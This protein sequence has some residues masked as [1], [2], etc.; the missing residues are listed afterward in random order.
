MEE[1]LLATGTGKKG[2]DESPVLSEVKKQLRLAG[3]LVVG[4]LLQNVVQ[5][6][7]VMFVG[8]LGELALSAASMAT[9]F[10]N[11]TG[12]SLLAGMACSLDTLCGQAYGAGQHRMLGVYKQRAML[13]LSLASVPVAALWAYTGRIL[14]LLGQDPEI[15]A[16]AGGYIRWMIPALLAYGPLQCHVRFLQ[17]QNVVVPVMLS[18]GATALNHPLVCWAL[19]HGLRM[20][21]KGAALA[22]AVSFLTNLSI[23]ALYVRLSPSCSRTWTGFSR[24]AFRGLAGFLKLAVPSALMHGVVV[25]R[26]AGAALRPAPKPQAGDGGPVHLPEH[27]LPGV[28]GAARARRCHKHA[29]VERARGGAAGGGAAGGARG[30]A[31]G[32]GGGRVGGAGDAAGARRVGVRLQQRGGGGRLRRPDDAHP[33]HV[34]RV[35]RPPVR[36]LRRCQGLRAAEDGRIRQPRGV[37]PRRHSRGLLLR[38]RLPPW[39]NGAVVRDMVRAGGADALAPRHFR[40]RDRLGQRGGE[41]KGQSLHFFAASRYDD[42][43]S[44][45]H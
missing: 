21:S 25:V 42:V 7:S 9:S 10:A 12:F 33:R 28:H 17:T 23:L 18:S 2:D 41:G 45:K 1:Q 14:L 43:R 38:L 24:D 6:I 32:A 30:D 3:P 29:R 11:V 39:R 44:S 26:A 4:C 36:P 13:V 31:A 27:Q 22:N 34:R 5:M 16:G 35:R 20:G 15:A 37:L 40:V 8:H 19:V